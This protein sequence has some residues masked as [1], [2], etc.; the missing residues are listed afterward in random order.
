MSASVR[1]HDR[2]TFIRAQIE[3]GHTL[4]A[5]GDMLGITRE[6]VRQ[7]A[8]R[9]GV[10]DRGQHQPHDV[11]RFMAVARRAR[12]L[13]ATA[14][15]LGV[16]AGVVQRALVAIGA[17]PALTRLWRMRQKRSRAAELVAAMQALATRLGRTPAI[18]DLNAPDAGTACHMV[19]VQAFGSLR[20]AQAASGLVPN[21]QGRPARACCRNGHAMS[22]A[23]LLAY[24]NGTRTQRKCR[25]CQNARKRA[26]Y[27]ARRAGAA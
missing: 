9:L 10:T 13:K 19:Y 25:A 15:E 7:I 6:R 5:V 26:V 17:F 8:N 12:S 1:N 18:A 24:R 22:G 11:V 21:A 14:S 4:Q 2:D 23:N 20:A 16:G 27:H 3:A